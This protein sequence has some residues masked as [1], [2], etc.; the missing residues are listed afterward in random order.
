MSNGQPGIN[1]S[2]REVLKRFTKWVPYQCSGDCD[3]E[4]NFVNDIGL[5]RPEGYDRKCRIVEVLERKDARKTL[6]EKSIKVLE[7]IRDHW[8]RAT[9]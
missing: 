5:S 3:R 7:D 1:R 6:S 8:Y 9:L 2:R 4:W